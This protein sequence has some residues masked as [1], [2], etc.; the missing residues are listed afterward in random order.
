MDSVFLPPAITGHRGEDSVS[1]KK[2]DKGDR[3]WEVRKEVLGWVMDGA[4]RCIELAEKKQTE[5]LK[6]IKTVL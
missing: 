4:S 2:L 5:I 1:L 3:L 6:E